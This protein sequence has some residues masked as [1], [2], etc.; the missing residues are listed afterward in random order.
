[1]DYSLRREANSNWVQSEG[2]IQYPEPAPHLAEYLRKTASDW[3]ELGVLIPAT[4]LSYP[5]KNVD[6]TSRPPRPNLFIHPT[7]V[8]E[9]SNYDQLATSVRQIGVYKKYIFKWKRGQIY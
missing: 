7:F 3:T 4:K 8:I 1:M 2:W 6:P 5:P 9:H